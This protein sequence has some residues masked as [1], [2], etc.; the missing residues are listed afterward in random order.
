[1]EVI[2]NGAS[3]EFW[4]NRSLVFSH[5]TNIPTGAVLPGVAVETNDTVE[6]QVDIDY[7]AIRLRNALG[8]RW[9]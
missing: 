9:T 7:V 4:L 1:M 5:A 8:Q 6:K 2:K 3:W